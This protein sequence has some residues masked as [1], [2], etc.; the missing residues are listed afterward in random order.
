MKVVY[1]VFAIRIANKYC[2]KYWY[3]S[4]SKECKIN[5]FSRIVV[6]RS[7]LNSRVKI[8]QVLKLDKLYTSEIH[9]RKIRPLKCKSDGIYG[10]SKLSY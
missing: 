6:S 5:D 9:S 4:I 10:L 1:I 3:F 8:S 7:T 2:Y